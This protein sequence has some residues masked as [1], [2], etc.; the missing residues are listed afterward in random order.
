LQVGKPG[1]DRLQLN[2]QIGPGITGR[3]LQREATNGH[4]RVEAG[5]QGLFDVFDSIDR[6]FGNRVK[7]GGLQLL[8]HTGQRRPC[9]IDDV[10]QRKRREHAAF[11]NLP[12]L[13]HDANCGVERFRQRCDPNLARL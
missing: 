12:S 1:D 10:G 5:L 9:A 6:R 7:A 4:R 8:E 11:G 2:H 13:L 3:L